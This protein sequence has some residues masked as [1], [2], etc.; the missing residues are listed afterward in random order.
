MEAKGITVDNNE[1]PDNINSMARTLT[2]QQKKEGLVWSIE[3]MAL[4][5]RW[6]TSLIFEMLINIA[7]LMKDIDTR[8]RTVEKNP[9]RDI[10][11]C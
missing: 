1:I 10:N 6:S 3:V 4:I 7:I 9:S 2:D 5:N 8:L 11:I